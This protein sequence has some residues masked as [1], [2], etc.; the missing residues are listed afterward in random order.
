MTS[1][2]IEAS[3]EIIRSYPVVL[4][5]RMG[6][7]DVALEAAVAAVQG[8]LRCI[9]ITMTTPNATEIMRALSKRCPDAFVGA[10]TV[11][12]L[13]NADAAFE[14]GARFALSPVVDTKIIRYCNELGM[15]AVPGAATPTEIYKAYEE[16]GARLVKI[17][18]VNLCGGLEF[19]RAM[20]GP[21]PQVPL[22]PTSGI[23]LMALPNYLLCD[24]VLAIGASRQILQDSAIRQRQWDVITENAR[25]WM[26]VA[27]ESTHT[28]HSMT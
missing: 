15:L 19:V 7:P 28:L 20:K 4:C 1:E 18:P 27:R 21:L 17:F 10:G 13:Q 9:E 8:G 26:T 22:L 3:F 14:A 24:N 5:V 23:D 2:R 25:T 12:T 16:G 6:D 11:L